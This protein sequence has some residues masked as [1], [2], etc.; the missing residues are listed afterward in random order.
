MKKLLL[1]LAALAI[2]ASAG[3]AQTFH[4]LPNDKAVK[5]G[6]LENGLT[7]YIRHNEKP[8]G[9]AEFYLATDVGAIQETPD[10]DGLAHFLEHMCFNGT[11]DFPGKGILD[12]LQ[13]IGASFGGNVNAA[14]GVE[15]TV[16]MLNNIPLVRPTVID[17]CILIMQNYAHFVTNDPAEIDK[18]RGV[19][20]EERR[21]RRNASWRMHEKSLPY[22]YGDNKFGECTLI[23]SQENLLGFKPESLVNFYKTWYHPDM[24]AFIV[25]GDVDVDYVEGKIREIFGAIPKEENPQ[26]KATFPFQDFDEPRIGVI[27]DPEAASV[28]FEVLWESE[29]MPKEFNGTIESL[30]TDALKEIVSHVAMERFNDITSK[31]DAPF[32]SAELGI[33]N[34]NRFTEVV[35]GGVSAKEG[36]ALSALKAFLIEVE[37]LQK[38][39]ITDDEFNRAK[40][41]ILS[42]YESAANKA[43]TRENSQ[44]VYPLIYNFFENESYMDP[45]EEYQWA[46]MLFAQGLNSAIVNESLKTL[47]D[48]GKNLVILYKGPE[49]EGLVSPTV[50]Q[51]KEVVNE[52]KEADIKPNVVEEL[53][54]EF[55]DPA[56]LTGSKAKETGTDPFGAK[57]Y[58][59]G[60]GVKVIL[61]RN[62]IQKDRVT[63]NISKNGGESLIPTEDMA[64]FNGTIFS[65]YLGNTGVAGFSNTTVGKMLAG[66]NIS[67]NPFINSLRNGIQASSTTKD[68]ETAL[69]LAYLYYAQPRFDEEEFNTGI[70]QL[71]AILPNIV[72]QPNYKFQ[73]LAMKTIYNNH[74]RITVISP[75]L[76]ASANLATIEKNY[77]M[78]FADAAGVTAQISGDFDPEVVLPL[79][80]KY[81]GSL[82]AGKKAPEFKD[83]NKNVAPGNR[84]E[85]VT[86]DME[87][88]KTTVT[89]VYSSPIE[90][91]RKK[92][93]ALDAAIYILRIRYTNT[94]REEEGGTY[95]A[96][97]MADMA[98]EPKG[99]AV[100]QVYFDCKP[101]LADKLRE[102][103]TEGITNLATGGPTADEFDKA[104]K[105]LEKNIP[106]SREKLSYWAGVVRDYHRYGFNRDA[107]YE[108]A[109][110][111]LTPQDIKDVLSLVINSGNYVDIVMRPGKTTE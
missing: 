81:I 45:K 44:L 27:T 87:T 85:D 9:R 39:G 64:S 41:E 55:I 26:P 23:G 29:A 103:A 1:T 97:S 4:S 7:Y 79:V 38:F 51:I 73:K 10:Q 13:S 2:A 61:Y 18:E 25:V 109:V 110:K 102:I 86:V 101:E 56:S 24:Q 33:G 65:T 94:L 77:R 71:E 46:Q 63:I 67:V 74:P 15:Q 42:Q 20:V 105:N 90:Y 68:V 59:L 37:K 34:L 78:L 84:I 3:F 48:N 93:V 62:D 35:M 82:P 91:S 57:L 32:L 80:E 19:I 69:Q 76:L 11:K 95:G 83:W 28:S 104:L 52:V 21:A 50:E 8:A 58:T 6:K 31:A 106:E 72:N 70:K 14:T 43:D 47:T 22:Y 53:P 100:V 30:M 96:Q 5:V 17:T 89:R 49:K 36:E 66:K 111:S 88:P 12:W 75:E 98:F 60:N 107:D 92:D 99:Y 16:Y 40:E 54:K 108:A